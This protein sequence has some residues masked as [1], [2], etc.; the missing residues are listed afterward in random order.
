AKVSL[1]HYAQTTEE[2]F[3]RAAGGAHSG[4]LGA[5]NPAQRVDADSG[6]VSHKR[7]T[8][9]ELA[10]S[11]ATP[12]ETQLVAAKGLSGE[13]GIRTRGG[14]L[15]PLTGLANRRYRPLSHLSKILPFNHLKTI[16]QDRSADLYTRS[17]TH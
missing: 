5:Q 9:P 11:S 13:D 4:A 10:G 17:Y 6:G 7:D 15:G 12:C 16:I 3:G 2:H 14:G 1:K 8:N